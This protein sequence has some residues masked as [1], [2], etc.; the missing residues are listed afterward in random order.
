MKSVGGSILIG[1][2]WSMLVMGILG[3]L[4]EESRTAGVLSAFLITTAGWSI[5]ILLRHSAAHQDTNTSRPC[6]EQEVI[7]QS[8]GVIQRL[9]KDLTSQTG[10]MH[11]ELQ[12]TQAIFSQAIETLMQSF[13]SL[14]TQAQR[15]QA[16]GM[17]VLAKQS[18]LQDPSTETI[19]FEK[20]ASKTSGTLEKF[21]ENVMENSRLA[22]GLV[23]LT[24]E[25]SQQMRKVLGMLDEIE[26]ISKQT[27]LLALNAAIEAARAG[28]TGRGFAVVADQVRELSSRT[29]HF[30]LQIRDMLGN[31][32]GSI[33]AADDTIHE[34]A[35][36]DMSFA[37]TSKN[38][39]EFALLEIDAQNHRTEDVI[40]EM[41]QISVEVSQSVNSAVISLQFQDMVTQLIGHVLRRLDMLNEMGEEQQRMAA[42]L[43][44]STDAGVQVLALNELR[45]H[46]ETLSDKLAQLK[47]QVIHNPVKQNSF[48]SGEVELFS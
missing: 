2:F 1:V 29:S 23:E 18:H 38:D 22:T 8:A 39:V 35:S 43:S 30:S 9:A 41:N 48:A 3:F 37:L 28:E 11:A 34:M 46:V 24:T 14:N 32:S 45:T 27:N 20:F 6:V 25:I 44:N 40:G 10:E 16:V 4:V 33:K 13:H 21:T 31:M 7:Q 47:L 26:A 12:R 17:A 42:I 15:Q 19:S 5:L 36:Q